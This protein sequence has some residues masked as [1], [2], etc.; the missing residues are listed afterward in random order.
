M[1]NN[2]LRH[3]IISNI[4]LSVRVERILAGSLY[5]CGHREILLKLIEYF[6]E[7][8]FCINEIFETCV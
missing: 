6:R 8:K 2:I 4:I 3:N 7:N 1:G 5:S